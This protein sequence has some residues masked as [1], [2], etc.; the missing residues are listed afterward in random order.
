M[1]AYIYARIDP[2]CMDQMTFY[3][4]SLTATTLINTRTH[5]RTTLLTNVCVCTSM[6][7]R[8]R[9]TFFLIPFASRSLFLS[10]THTLFKEG[11]GEKNWML[12]RVFGIKFVMIFMTLHNCNAIHFEY[13]HINLLR[14][15]FF[16]FFFGIVVCLW[17]APIFPFWP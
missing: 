2:L 3:F 10:L 8:L 4:H 5:A 14:I 13:F 7:Q 11:T 1:Y 17:F 15:H 6:Y 12:W 16:F 9:T